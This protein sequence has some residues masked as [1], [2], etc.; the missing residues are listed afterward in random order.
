M[1]HDHEARPLEMRDEPFDDNLCCDL[2]CLR[3]LERPAASQGK[4]QR[5]HTRM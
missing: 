1:S 2:G 4:R 3:S 5:R